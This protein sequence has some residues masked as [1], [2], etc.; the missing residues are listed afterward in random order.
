M[1][2]KHI[3]FFANY[4]INGISCRYR[5]FY[6]LNELKNK[7]NITFNFIFP[8]YRLI[9]ILKFVFV[10]M[11]VL[12][13]RKR[14]SIV[15]FQK[16]HR[17]GIYTFLLKILL[18][19]RNKNTVYDIDDADYLRYPDKNFIYFIKNCE[20]VFVGSEE[21][22]IYANQFNTNILLLTSPIIKHTSKKES[23]NQLLHV[24]WIGDYG[25]NNGITYDFSHK[26]SVENI[27]FPAIKK[28]KFNLKLTLLGVKNLND[29]NEILQEFSENKN[30]LLNIPEEVNWLNEEAIYRR[31][32]EFDIG[33]SPMIDHE[34]TRSKSAFK[35]KQYLSC[36]IPVLAS[37]VGENLNFVKNNQNGFICKDSNDFTDRLIQ[38]EEMNK[39]DYEN[40][41][42]HTYDQYNEFSLKN[43]CESMLNYFKMLTQ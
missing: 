28:L 11:K 36:G 41:I 14:K 1:E 22:R 37:P 10:W 7:Y 16:I 6:V 29:K 38:I 13:F 2:I 33:V 42:H 31:I 25:N 43:Y 17:K 9:E 4:N 15:I 26:R 40:L 5:G 20:H 8:G 39:E 23:R 30:V 19:L 21:L 24:G 27:L 3:Y 35:I 32:S 12:C 18:Q 34:F